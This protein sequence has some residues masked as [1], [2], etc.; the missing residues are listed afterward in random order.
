MDENS[1]LSGRATEKDQV[2]T[3]HR[4]CVA[5]DPARALVPGKGLSPPHLELGWSRKGTVL[6]GEGAGG[7]RLTHTPSSLPL[8]RLQVEWE[9]AELRDQLL[10]VTQERDL[11]L[12]KSQ[13]LQSKLESLEQVLK[14]RGLRWRGRR[15]EYWYLAQRGQWDSRICPLW[16]TGVSGPVLEPRAPFLL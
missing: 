16:G 13:G 5:W 14:V 4:C 7:T 3:P 8:P 6:P 15:G 9:N 12:R 11:A 10:G 2:A 1:R